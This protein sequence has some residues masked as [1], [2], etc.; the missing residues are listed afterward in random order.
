ML[1]P[2]KVEN[3]LEI[4]ILEVVNELFVV[5]AVIVVVIAST[6]DHIAEYDGENLIFIFLFRCRHT[7]SMITNIEINYNSCKTYIFVESWV[8]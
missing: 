2:H 3:F 4:V 7:L 5:D 8:S 6:A 1:P